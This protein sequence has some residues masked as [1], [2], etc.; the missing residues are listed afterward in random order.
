M[1]SGK[2][3]ADP[4][5]LNATRQMLD[6]LDALMERM[7]AVPIAESP[8]AAPPQ[9]AATQ[10]S[11]RPMA[12]TLTL[13][14]APVDE[15]S[16]PYRPPSGPAPAT[17]A[18]DPAHAATN[19]S[20]LPPRGAINSSAAPVWSEMAGYPS[21]VYPPAEASEPYPELP[22]LPDAPAATPEPL[23]HFALPPASAPSL[24]EL[25][26]DVPEPPASLAAWIILPV[27]WGNRLFDQ[28]TL[29]LGE[30]GSWLRGTIGRSALGMAGLILFGAALLWLA[31]DW[32]GWTW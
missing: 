19:P 15:P 26:A 7:L 21:L 11:S 29:L 20:H 17:P 5:A 22:A 14:Q 8:E 18:F 24:D 10:P 27:L 28:G 6:E 4:P 16:A 12:A 1:A 3:A 31:R 25:L 23:S 9:T 32:L 30:N 13:L 2:P